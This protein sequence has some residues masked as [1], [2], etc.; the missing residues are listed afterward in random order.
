MRVQ[1]P[2]PSAVKTTIASHLK[3]SITQAAAGAASAI[4]DE[5]TLTGHLCA[6]IQTLSNTVQVTDEQMGGTWHWSLTYFKFRGRGPR[7]TENYLGADGVIEIR[8]QG[9]GQIHVKSLL[10]Q[11]KIEGNQDRQMLIGQCAKLSTWRE[12]AFVLNFG[13][14]GF[15]AIPLNEVFAKKGLLSTADATPLADYLGGPF[16]DC[17][18]GDN[19][20]RYDHR[21]HRLIWRTMSG[22][23]VT[24]KFR[25]RHSIALAI[26]GPN[27]DVL[28][29][30]GHVEVL[31]EDIRKHRMRADEAEILGLGQGQQTPK[32]IAKASRALARVY[33]P[34][35][36]VEFDSDVRDA[37]LARMQEVNA[38]ADRMKKK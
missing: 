3:A 4:E 28:S 31:P 34:D 14:D 20:L 24:S 15:S 16:L 1:I 25:V 9:L 29:D 2:I 13:S 21:R 12:A 19:E 8:F 22:D 30:E 26:Q 37:M 7:A 10:F 33:H 18:V 11:T 27:P 23:M 6:K 36:W 17:E 5:D 38:A 35:K 32:E